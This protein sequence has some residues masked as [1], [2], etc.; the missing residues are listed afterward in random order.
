M[1]GLKFGNFFFNT[2]PGGDNKGTDIIGDTT[3][4]RLQIIR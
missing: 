2:D 1:R 3:V 4:F